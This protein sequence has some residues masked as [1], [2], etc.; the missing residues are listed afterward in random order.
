M[1][2]RLGFVV[3]AAADG[4]QALEVFKAHGSEIACVILDLTMP[5]MDGKECF[6][7]LRR[8]RDDVKVVLSSGYDEQEV[9]RRFAGESAAAFVQKPYTTKGLVATLR[10]VLD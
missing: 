7:E 6:A 8:L 9:I 10:K 1:L 2:E 3:L 5:K 4:R